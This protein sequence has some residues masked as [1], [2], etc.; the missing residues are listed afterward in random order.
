[1][2]NVEQ[3]PRGRWFFLRAAA[4][5]CKNLGMRFLEPRIFVHRAGFTLL[6]ALVTMGII[7]IMTGA[8]YVT[9]RTSARPQAVSRTI[10]TTLLAIRT[11]QAKAASTATLSPGQIPYGYGAYFDIS[12]SASRKKIIIFAD[13]D[14]DKTRKSD[15]TEDVQTIALPGA[16]IATLLVCSNAT[17]PCSSWLNMGTTLTTYFCPPNPNT[18]L[19]SASDNSRNPGPPPNCAAQLAPPPPLR[20]RT[21]A[22]IIFQLP[23]GSV[24]LPAS[25][26]RCLVINAAGA[27]FV[28]TGQGPACP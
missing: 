12:S 19:F 7:I 5:G 20:T 26:P 14:G 3:K 2:N 4:L 22:R 11:A 25:T 16:Q 23:S 1:M 8:V 17:S 9:V 18:F 21:E 10:H 28:N 27:A 15:A 24:P 13:V 6:E